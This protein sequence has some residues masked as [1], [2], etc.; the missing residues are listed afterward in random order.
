MECLGYSYLDSPFPKSQRRRVE[1]TTRVV[2]PATDF[3]LLEPNRSSLVAVSATP[4][5]SL[6]PALQWHDPQP[7]P[8]ATPMGAWPLL[9]DNYQANDLN[10]T[11]DGVPSSVLA[12]SFLSNPTASAL[13]KASDAFTSWYDTNFLLDTPHQQPMIDAGSVPLDWLPAVWP[14][15]LS[16][17][18]SHSLVPHFTA[19]ISQDLATSGQASLFQALVNLESCQKDTLE[20]S[21]L[22][23]QASSICQGSAWLSPDSEDD[24]ESSVTGNEADPE[25][26]KDIICPTRVMD[27]NVLSDPLPSILQICTPLNFFDL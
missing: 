21:N 26:V 1:P 14:P 15:Q 13:L 3:P 20:H 9:R 24:D 7:L 8:T 18:N 10:T 25:G 12:V 5:P 11:T 27:N 4:D 17:S 23:S 19:G 6:T 2:S 16:N 22:T